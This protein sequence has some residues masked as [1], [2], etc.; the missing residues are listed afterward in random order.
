MRTSGDLTARRRYCLT[1]DAGC[2]NDPIACMFFDGSVTC[3]QTGTTLDLSCNGMKN[4]GDIVPCGDNVY[5]LGTTAH[6]WR[7]VH[8]GP[9]SL[10]IGSITVMGEDTAGAAYIKNKVAT[11]E[12][13]VGS[14]VVSAGTTTASVGGWRIGATG[15]PGTTSYDLIATEN[16]STVSGT[17]GLSYSLIRNAGAS[18][19]GPIGPPG[20]TGAPGSPGATGSPGADGATGSPGSDGA[21]GATGAAGAGCFNLRVDPNNP[22]ASILTPSSVRAIDAPADYLAGWYGRWSSLEPSTGPCVRTSFQINSEFAIIGFS[23][24]PLYPSHGVTGYFDAAFCFDGGSGGGFDAMDICGELQTL[25]SSWNPTDVF[26]L[27]Y[28]DCAKEFR[29]YRNGLLLTTFKYA[30][31]GPL[32]L[33]GA[34]YIAQGFPQPTVSNITF[35]DSCGSCSSNSNNSIQSITRFAMGSAITVPAGS[36]PLAQI[37]FDTDIA[38]NISL[39]GSALVVNGGLSGDPDDTVT[40]NAYVKG[41]TNGYN[42]ISSLT[43]CTI[44]KQSGIP[45]TILHGTTMHYPAGNY[46]AD[47]SIQHN[48]SDVITVNQSSLL[49]MANTL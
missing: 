38:G 1:Q 49:V 13:I 29:F 35:C 6:R 8:I 44:P 40:I 14:T 9:G 10:Y 20:A 3:V 24:N 26:S 46:L 33:T 22:Y 16:I 47:L 15:T 48:G 4:V 17:T 41:T 43:G 21:T 11:T 27:S 19:I 32:Y 34:Y 37:T 45:L 25:G 31:S 23:A 36:T 39:W 7:D 5:S 28:D 42:S 18:G 2:C 12:I 30:A